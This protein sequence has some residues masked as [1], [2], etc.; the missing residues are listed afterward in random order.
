MDV[1]QR[2]AGQM[3][4]VGSVCLL[5]TM[6][7]H[8]PGGKIEYL[9]KTSALIVSSHSIALLSIPFFLT[10]FLG[11][12]QIWKHNTLIPTFS[13]FIMFIA[14]LAGMIAGSINGLAL[15]LFITNFEVP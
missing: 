11:L 4:L 9:I 2:N 10:G 12:S 14:Q 7:Y 5:A 3:L 13:F 1:S 6:V 15:P 8:P